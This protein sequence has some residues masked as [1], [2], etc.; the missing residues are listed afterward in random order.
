M[1]TTRIYNGQGLGN[2][3]WC[4]VVLRVI[5]KK[6]GYAFGIANPERLKCHDFMHL[7]TG[8]QVLGGNGPEG[9]PPRALPEGITYYYAEQEL[10]HPKNGMDIRM[11]DEAL[12]QIPDCTQIDGIMQDEKYIKEYKDEIRTW[13]A[14]KTE[15][16]PSRYASDEVCIINFRGGEYVRIPEVFLPQHYWDAAIAHM[17]VI[18]PNMRFVVATDDP[19][20][21]R[22]FFPDFEIS[23]ES[24]G[25][26]YAIILNAH[27]LILSNSSFAWFPAW[28]STSAQKI[29]APKYWAA[30]NVSD[31]YWSTGYAPT[32][33]F[34]YLD[35][36]GILHTY[37]E[38]MNEYESYQKKYP[39][40]FTAPA[41]PS[42]TTLVVSNY[43]NN[44]SWIPTYTENYKI[45]D[46]SKSRILSPYL[47]P[48][49]YF[50]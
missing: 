25:S 45:Y 22:K 10:R 4:Y 50:E 33:G 39:E 13:L 15:Y 47:A 12:M 32:S 35:R 23:H 21:A 46:Q 37:E 48:R 18:N 43:Y 29:I 36:E 9:G 1:I 44:L 49:D 5:A 41:I 11:Y 3:L 34:I 42:T 27:Y 6:H 28:L 31:G 16:T 17:R 7:D 40:L 14:L 20:T 24:I 26:D 30:H 19:K 2:Q 8:E 38:C